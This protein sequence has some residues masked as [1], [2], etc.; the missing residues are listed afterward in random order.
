MSW[1]TVYQNYCMYAKNVVR[2]R[3]ARH[4]SLSQMAYMLSFCTRAVTK[5]TKYGYVNARKLSIK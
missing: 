5:L 3:L 4:S 1:V 2:L